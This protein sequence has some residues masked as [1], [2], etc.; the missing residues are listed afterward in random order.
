MAGI[1]AYH[2]YDGD[3]VGRVVDTDGREAMSWL[4]HLLAGH[5]PHPGHKPEVIGFGD[6]WIS[7]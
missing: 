5:I 2:Y 4:A 1:P 7:F 6:C 3:G